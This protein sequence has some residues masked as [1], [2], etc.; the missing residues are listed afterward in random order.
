M[1]LYVKWTPKTYTVTFNSSGGSTVA[2]L[3]NVEHNTLIVAPTAPTKTGFDHD[4]W[5][6]DAEF[7]DEWDFA[8]DTVTEG[9]TLYTKWKEATASPVNLTIKIT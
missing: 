6:K 3:T 5:Y 7:T 4:G 1:T 8:I 2:N 9:I